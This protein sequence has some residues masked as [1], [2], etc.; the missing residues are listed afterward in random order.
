MFS[1]PPLSN[2]LTTPVATATGENS[3]DE[4]T[5]ISDSNSI[6]I[7]PQSLVVSVFQFRLLIMAE[8]A[9][10]AE[11]LSQREARMIIPC[12]PERAYLFLQGYTQDT[13]T[14]NAL[15]NVMDFIEPR[16]KEKGLCPFHSCNASFK[17]TSKWS[18]NGHLRIHGGEFRQESTCAYIKYPDEI[19]LGSPDLSEA[20]VQQ[21]I[22]WHQLHPLQMGYVG[23]EINRELELHVLPH[24]S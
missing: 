13:I 22:P 14:Y 18:I 23:P 16:R 9:V 17:G 1:Q 24:E 10:A 7:T 5:S 19:G 15:W 11:N 3:G 4:Q 12:N 2:G 6:Q 20:T 21:W 8:L